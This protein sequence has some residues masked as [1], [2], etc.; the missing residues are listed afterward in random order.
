VYAAPRPHKP[1]PGAPRYIR[2]PH[3]SASDTTPIIAALITGGLM[4]INTGVTV[5]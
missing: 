1:H 5:V 4:L 2:A 3:S